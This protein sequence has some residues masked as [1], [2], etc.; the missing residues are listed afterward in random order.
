MDKLHDPFDPDDLTPEEREVFDK[1]R[2]G[3]VYRLDREVVNL[4]RAIFDALPPIVR[5]L[6]VWLRAI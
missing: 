6:I 2:I 3:A 1:S 4:K 5:R